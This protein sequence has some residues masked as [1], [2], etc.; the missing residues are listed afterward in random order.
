MKKS[1]L[2]WSTVQSIRSRTRSVWKNSGYRSEISIRQSRS[3]GGLTSRMPSRDSLSSWLRPV[4]AS[5]YASGTY[6]RQIREAGQTD[7]GEERELSYDLT[8]D[9]HR[10]RH[11][12]PGCYDSCPYEGTNRSRQCLALT[13]PCATGCTTNR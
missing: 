12:H 13:I 4:C 11:A 5:D 9:P 7:R 6:R 2:L 1:S 8:P 10:Y 3:T